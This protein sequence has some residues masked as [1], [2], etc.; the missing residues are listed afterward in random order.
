MVAFYFEEHH[1]LRGLCLRALICKWY[2]ALIYHLLCQWSNSGATASSVRPVHLQQKSPPQQ[3]CVI[4]WLPI[5]TTRHSL[6][7]SPANQALFSQ[8]FNP[9]L[10]QIVLWSMPDFQAFQSLLSAWFCRFP[11]LAWFLSAWSSHGWI[12]WV[13]GLSHFVLFSVVIYILLCV[14]PLITFGKFSVV[15][16]S[17]YLVQVD[18][19]VLHLVPISIS[20]T[21]I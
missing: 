16:F 2:Q 21:K 15:S 19:C 1:F 5:R 4:V 8:H 10:S 6:I 17:S 7:Q 20:V 18:S 12:Y 9:S 13:C 11:P 14:S 3:G